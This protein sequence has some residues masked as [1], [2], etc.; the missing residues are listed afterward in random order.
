[1]YRRSRGL[2]YR[3]R[4][5][6]RMAVC[7]HS[8]SDHLSHLNVPIPLPS[9]ASSKSKPATIIH[10]LTSLTSP[11]AERLLPYYTPP[12]SRHHPWD[13]RLCKTIPNPRMT[14]R[15]RL[16]YIRSIQTRISDFHQD[17]TS[18]LIFTDGSRHRALGHRRTGAGYAAFLEGREIRTGSWG[19]GKRAGIYDAEMFALAGS[20]GSVTQILTQNPHIKHLIF[21]SDNQ[22]ALSAIT[23]TTAHPAQGASILFRRHIDSLLS[24][25]NPFDV[26]LIWIPGH[27]GILGNE[28]ADSIA[29]A[30]V[31]HHPIFAST[32]SWA[33]E[34]AK[35]RALKSWRTEWSAH[36]HTNLAA[37]ALSKPPSTKLSPFHR[38]F[39]DTR[40]THSRIIQTLLG[41]FFCGEYY[42]R[43][44]PTES[45]SCPCG[46]P[47]QTRTHILTDCPIYEAHRHHLR[48]VTRTLSLPVI[49]ST[50]SGLEAL[51]KF[52]TESHAFS[53]VVPD[54]SADHG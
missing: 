43:F 15:E 25:L 49:L 4:K 11:T 26:E 18:L 36:P 2:H 29:K 1:M 6:I 10:H 32:I 3:P 53:K 8:H 39:S 37:T 42:A 34:K 46:D 51:T 38:S 12:W 40:A 27:K 23:D 30:A 9:V 21:L 54:G 41:H 33:R 50:K 5:G 14:Q 17:P 7:A 52:V 19:L 16:A 35:S 28:R 47:H 22:A 44:V 24:T 20:A 31:N 48:S 13:N 45:A